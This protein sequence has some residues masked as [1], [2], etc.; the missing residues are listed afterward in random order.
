[1]MDANLEMRAPEK[2]EVK[3]DEEEPKRHRRLSGPVGWAA[4]LIAIALPIYSFLYI[5][6]LL[7]PLGLFVYSGTHN[8]IFLAAVLILLFLLVPATH[9]APRNRVPWYDFILIGMSLLGVVYIAIAYEALLLAG[10]ISITPTQQ[11]LGLFTIIAVMEAVRRTVGWVMIII[12]LFF[13]L[14]AKFTYLFPGILHGPHFST[15]RV[16]NY[17]YLS[18][19]G[20]FGM[21]LGIATTIIVSF[22]IFG[23]FLDVS[24]AGNT[25]IK[26]ALALLGHVRGGA[27]KVAVLGS[28]LFGTVTG[29]PIA[30]IGVVGSFT[31]PLMK[32]IGY[33]PVFAGAAEAAAACGGVIDPPVMGAVAFVMADFT[34][35]GYG[36]IAVAAILPAILYYLSLF[37]QLDLRAAAT[38]LVGLPKAELPKIRE[39]L[40]ESWLLGVPLAVLII[41]MMVLD[42]EPTTSVFIALGSLILLTMLSP[43]NRLTLSKAIKSLERAGTSMIDITPICALAGVIVGSITLTGLG[44]NLSS[45]LV[46]LSG[47]NLLVLSILTAVAIYIMGMGVAA[48]A[49]YIMMAVLVAPAMVQMGVPL[50]VAHF[51]IFYIGVSMFITP[52]YAPAAYVAAAM[53]GANPMRVGYQA[54]RLA[55][56][57]YLV[58]FVSIFQPALL[59]QGTVFEVGTAAVT[60]TIA[61]YALSVGFE[62]FCLTTLSWPERTI[63]LAGGFLLFIPS[64]K[65]IGPGLFLC[66][67]GFSVQWL[68]RKRKARLLA[69]AGDGV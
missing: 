60:A 12:V 48:I 34:G 20:I 30:E 51:F 8:A 7:T 28:A 18:N 63:W 2:I 67:I 15:A 4:R 50:L 35:I 29:S 9:S 47:G 58:P 64:I 22:M 62:G 32:R 43:R 33:S 25:F 46:T 53:A 61:V 21:V 69:K 38:G 65:L 27:A 55:I 23:A 40:K 10:G 17:L 52:P 36:K 3:I 56:V 39:A 42:E 26:L 44:I 59:W 66:C 13:L 19:Q 37:F 5:M 57:A 68:K 16:L 6:N 54:M 31:I 14:H 11:I 45:L 49:S 24:G 41:W 1:M